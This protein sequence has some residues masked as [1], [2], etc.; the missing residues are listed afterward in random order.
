M[1][2]INKNQKSLLKR[3]KLLISK[4]LATM[5]LKAYYYLILGIGLCV[6]SIME[7]ADGYEQMTK[8]HFFAIFGVFIIIDSFLKLKEGYKEFREGVNKFKD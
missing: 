4:I 2:N 8:H 5:R 3:V 7:I 1:N 6:S